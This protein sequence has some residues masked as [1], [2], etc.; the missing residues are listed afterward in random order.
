ML[1]RKNSVHNLVESAKKQINRLEVTEAIKTYSNKIN[2]FIDIIDIGKIKNSGHI[3]GAK[4]VPKRGMLKFLIDPISPYHKE[5]FN[6]YNFILYCSSDWRSV[7][8]KPKANNFG[9]LITPHLIVGFKKW[10]ELEGPIEE[11]K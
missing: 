3:L 11:T 8:A 7:L 6:N 10:L 9:L 1:K 2:L 5:F 4:R